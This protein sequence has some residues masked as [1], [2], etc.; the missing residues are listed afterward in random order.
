MYIHKH[1]GFEN[2]ARSFLS[3]KGIISP[4]RSCRTW[5]LKC[6]PVSKV[7]SIIPPPT[8]WRT[9][10][11]KPSPPGWLRA[12]GAAGWLR[13]ARS[14]GAACPTAYS[15]TGHSGAGL[16]STEAAW[17]CLKRMWLGSCTDSFWS[18]W[19]SSSPECILVL[20]SFVVTV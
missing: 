1:T 16:L 5:L 20:W 19:G 15:F 12:G 9:G 14:P 4:K 10:C 2:S 11:G 18:A 17:D 13:T 3:A 8:G 6:F 7:V